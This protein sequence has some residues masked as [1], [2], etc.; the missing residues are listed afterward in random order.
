MVPNQSKVGNDRKSARI[1]C[2][3]AE[4]RSIERRS[5]GI[6]RRGLVTA[7]MAEAETG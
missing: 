3:S 5:T 2:V 1:E 7:A 6:S 4:R